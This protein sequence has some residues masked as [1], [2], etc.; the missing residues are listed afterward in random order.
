VGHE[1][2][3]DQTPQPVATSFLAWLDAELAELEA[4][5]RG[6][7]WDHIAHVARHILSGVRRDD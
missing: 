3:E 1:G 7:P 2:D 5:D 6:S 4:E